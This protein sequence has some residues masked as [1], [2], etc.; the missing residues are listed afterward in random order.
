M[1][2]I[3]GLYITDLCK[4]KIAVSDDVQTEMRRLRTEG[5]LALSVNPI[6]KV[7]QINFKVSFLNARSLHKHIEDVRKDI[8]Y[9]KT[10]V[11]I[12]SETRFTQLDNDNLYLLEDDKYTLFRN[13]ATTKDLQNT[14]P[15][16]GTA[17]Y[18]CV[19][20]YPG[21]P[22]CFNQNGVEITIL[23]FMIIPHITIVAVY[24]SPAVSI[25]QMCS[26]VRQ[27]LQ[28]LSSQFNLF[29]GDFNVNWLNNSQRTPLYNL[30]IRDNAYR[31]LVQYR[32]T[33]S[34]TCIDHIYNNLP[35]ATVNFGILETYFS[36]HKAIYALLNSFN[37]N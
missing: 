18:S 28:S 35:E 33:D 3:D 6:Y 20:F 37:R 1:T 25:T 7:S 17:V 26:A 14:R 16:G 15:F 29:I 32:T 19:D 8:N 36:D 5:Q 34:S 22:Y 2:T 27:T 24:R 30:F 12:F 11:S 9:S 31:Q 10:D 13:D 23:R 4:D 21:Y